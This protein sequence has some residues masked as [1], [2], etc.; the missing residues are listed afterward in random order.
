VD[1]KL[2]ALIMPVADVDRA[3][4]FYIERAGFNVD[5]D[6]EAAGFRVVQLTPLGSACSILLMSS[7]PMAPGTLKGL[8]LC[9]EDIEAARVELV[10]RGLD[11]SEPYHFVGGA[12][13]PGVDPKRGKYETYLSFSD[14]DGNEWLVQEIGP[15]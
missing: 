12:Q 9:V 6:F 3:K 8:H 10:G 1:Y 5:V 13:T 7:N 2:E 15:S 14:P 4:A 11:I